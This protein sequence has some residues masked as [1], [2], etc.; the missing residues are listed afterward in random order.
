MKGE[1]LLDRIIAGDQSAFREL[2]RRYRD[3][4][5]LSALSILHDPDEAEEIVQEVF[6][7]VHLHLGGLRDRS[8]FERWLRSIS[9]NLAINRL[10]EKARRGDYVPLDE[11]DPENLTS[12]PADEK[13]LKIYGSLK[14]P[15]RRSI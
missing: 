1:D 15:R 13:V 6:L 12:P 14:A 9:R 7:R 3:T 4:V 10:K 2:V 11:V 8:A 5:F